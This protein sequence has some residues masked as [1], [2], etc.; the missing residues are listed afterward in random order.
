MTPPSRPGLLS[1]H[2]RGIAI[3]VAGILVLSPDSLL[4]RLVRADG[5]TLLFW[6][7]A[8]L[9]G[10][11]GTFL[12]LRYRGQLPRALRGIGRA[13]FVAGTIAGVGT[14][15]FVFA[16]LHTTVANTLIIIGLSPLV[17]AL[18]GRIFLGEPVYRHTWIAI[19][20]ALVGVALAASASVE[21]GNALGDLLAALTACCV[22]ANLTAL[23]AAGSADMTP[24]VGWSGVVAMLIAAPLA[25]PLS[26]AGD[27]VLTLGALGLIVLPVSFALIALAPRYLPAHEVSLI[28]LLEMAI[29]PYWVWL[30]LGE[31]PGPR[32][33]VGGAIVLATLVGHSIAGVR[34]DRLG[35][36]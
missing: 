11:L 32:A 34:R 35:P 14:V 19:P 1:N 9:A 5:W 28:L 36:I 12:L 30:A 25:A 7:G 33:A 17:A 31:Q 15:S 23:R 10:S 27:D 8:L 3:A 26:V 4:V 29:G 16:L 20:C 2:L 18:L 6:R 24:A 13:G 22:A 21:G